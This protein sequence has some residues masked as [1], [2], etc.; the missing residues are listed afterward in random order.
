MLYIAITLWV[1]AGLSFLIF[2]YT[3]FPRCRC[4][5][6]SIQ[7]A[8]AIVKSAALFLRDVPSALI[9]PLVFGLLIIAFWSFWITM[10]LFVYSSGDIRGSDSTPFATVDWNDNIRLQMI[11]NGRY[12]LIF[13]LFEGFWCNALLH[14]L[15]EFILASSC[16]IWYFS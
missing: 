2:M 8:I 1:I 11:I 9:V 7:L 10:F 16:A 3:I 15:C 4:Y 5:F 13:Q 14:A 6:R 12:M